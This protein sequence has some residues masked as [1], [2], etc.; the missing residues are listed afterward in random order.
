VTEERQKTVVLGVTGCIA[1]YKACEIVRS[2]MRADVRVK[3]VMTEAATRFVGPLTFRT[4]TGEPV[5]NS[6]WDDATTSRVFHVSL[7][8]EADVFLIAPCT[9][10][11]LAKL[12]HGAADDI[13]TTTALATEAPM[14]IAPAM[15]TH[16]WRD[17]ATQENLAVLRERGAIVVE[18]D[19][20]ELACGDV[21]EGRLAGIEEVA[22]AVHAEL[23]RVRDLSGV[24][25]LV[26]AGPTYEPI[27]PVRFIGNRSS[28][29]TGYAI[30]EE[31]ARRGA[32]VTLVSGPTALPD[33][34]GCAVTRVQTAAEMHRAAMDA[35]A[36]ADA[37][38]ATA[39][40]SDLRPSVISARKLKKS[41][42]PGTL[43]LERTAD[44]LAEMGSQRGGRV[45]I[46]FAAESHDVIGQA[47]R[48]LTSKDV[49]LVVANDITEPGLGFGSAD[50]RV[51]LVSGGG[52]EELPVMSKRELARI[53]C[54]RMVA[55]LGPTCSNT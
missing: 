44:I 25:L 23:S 21:G 14:I 10:N 9:A 49:D 31:A 53:I 29:R 33:P 34:F 42:T 40:V 19:S 35:Y 30:A 50:N 55:L 41:E 36:S 37:V 15:N 18:P 27:D 12:A 32:V 7:A 5:V 20:G 22:A 16:M 48:K 1:A 46:G 47:R 39:A 38:V 51:S 52:V 17:D 54:D 45:L 43:A 2:L 13:L 24:R 6:L 8:E 11:V 28:G 26:T 4:L 3:V